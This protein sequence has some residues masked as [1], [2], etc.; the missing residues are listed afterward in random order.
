[1][2][3]AQRLLSARHAIENFYGSVGFAL[4]LNRKILNDILRF[5]MVQ[6]IK[7]FFPRVLLLPLVGI[8][9]PAFVIV[10]LSPRFISLI[11]LSK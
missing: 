10:E 3:P 9:K 11:R 5:E 2:T 8:C 6:N 1:M 7:N 4:P